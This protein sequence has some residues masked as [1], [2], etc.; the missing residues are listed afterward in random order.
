[1]ETDRLD[2]TTEGYDYELPEERIAQ[3]PVIPRDQSR[4]LVVDSLTSHHHRIFQDL[5]NYLKSGDLLIFNDTRVIPARLYGNKS[6]GAAVE[7]LLIEERK[8]NCWLALVKPGRRFK[9]GVRVEFESLNSTDQEVLQ[10]LSATVVETDAATGGRLLQF[11]LPAGQSLIEQLDQFGHIPFPPYVTQSDALPQQYQTI[12]A[13]RP[14]AVAAPTAG[15]HFTEELFERLHHQGINKAFVTLHVGVGTFR[16]VEV[17]DITTHQM[18]AE[19]IEVSA[20]TVEQ[21]EKTKA[22]GGRIIAVGTTVVRTLE[23]VAMAE[24]KL[25]PYCGKTEAFIYPGYQFRVIDGLITNFHLPRSSLMMLVAA[26]IGRQ[27]L[28]DLYQDAIAQKAEGFAHPYRF[29][30]FGDGMLILPEAVIS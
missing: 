22:N 18:H 19:W 7:I 20:E 8:P 17:K 14:G 21:I 9:I 5:P 1:M 30:S 27:R 28:L 25:T 13:Q 12:Y 16:P 6:S 2:W 11:D 4:L 26:L 23:G 10:P 24:G 3:N 15:L 29:Y